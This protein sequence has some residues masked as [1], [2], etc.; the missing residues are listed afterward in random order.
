MSDNAELATMQREWRE[1]TTEAIHETAVKVDLILAKMA[2]MQRECATAA[3]LTAVSN[4]VT[5]LEN[6]RQKIIGA[7]CV[8]NV[9]GAFILYLATK[10]WK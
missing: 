1:S 10:F 7:A 5:G 8:L 3:Q 9:I 4:R 6:D 2:E